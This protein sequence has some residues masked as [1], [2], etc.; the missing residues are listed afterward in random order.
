MLIKL[1]SFIK[2]QY[3]VVYHPGKN[4]TPKEPK[5]MQGYD[6]SRSSQGRN[7]GYKDKN[8]FFHLLSDLSSA[9][10]F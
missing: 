2:I 4:Y 3:P 1:Q 10:Y 7:S 6:G 8:S 9:I 5:Y